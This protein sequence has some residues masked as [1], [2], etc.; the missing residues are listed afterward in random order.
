MSAPKAILP[1]D[2]RT[3]PPSPPRFGNAGATR[4]ASSQH[5]IP[6]PSCAKCVTCHSPGINLQNK[7]YTLS[8]FV[9]FPNST[10]SLDGFLYFN[11]IYLLNL[12]VDSSQDRFIRPPAL[13]VCT[14]PPLVTDIVCM[15]CQSH[16]LSPG[17]LSRTRKNVGRTH[18]QGI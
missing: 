8:G 12:A 3:K 9:A 13:L 17:W 6:A 1:R 5:Q 15:E 14:F 7:W 2:F 4:A 18:E 16:E 11:L 10:L